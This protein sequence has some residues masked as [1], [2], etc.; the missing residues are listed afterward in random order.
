MAK[1][2][3]IKQIVKEIDKLIDDDKINKTAL[4]DYFVDDPMAAYNY[5][6]FLGGQIRIMFL[7]I[8]IVAH[9]LSWCLSRDLRKGGK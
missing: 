9:C 6:S 2:K 7:R 8:S 1:A 5:I 4:A 3:T